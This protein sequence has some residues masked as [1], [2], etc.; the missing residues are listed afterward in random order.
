MEP[1]RDSK[2]FILTGSVEEEEAEMLWTFKGRMQ[3]RE[4]PLPSVSLFWYCH[5]H[6]ASSRGT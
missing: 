1:V 5:N 3:G 6:T 4:R 2:A